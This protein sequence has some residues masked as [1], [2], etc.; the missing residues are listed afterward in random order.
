[1]REMS[2][3]AGLIEIVRDKREEL[4]TQIAQDVNRQGQDFGIEV[5]DAAAD[6]SPSETL[7]AGV[8]AA[9]A[10]IAGWLATG[11]AGDDARRQHGPAQA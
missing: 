8:S 5:V 10:R 3:Y 7:P 4:M 1:M 6:A 2:Q 9:A 11:D